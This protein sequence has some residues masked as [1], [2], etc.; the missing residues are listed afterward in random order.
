MTSFL[1]TVGFSHSSTFASVSLDDGVLTVA[2]T[3]PS[4]AEREATIVAREIENALDAASKTLRLLVLDMGELRI[5]S[6]IGLGVCIDA[7]NAARK[8]GAETVVFRLDARLR[9]LFRMTRVDRLYTMLD[10]RAELGRL[11]AA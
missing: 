7:R 3:G 2:F 11:V 4:L 8:R 9:E 6:S 5:M 1:P 10:S